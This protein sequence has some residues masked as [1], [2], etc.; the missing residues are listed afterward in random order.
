MAAL[1]EQ[2]LTHE[3]QGKYVEAET[4]RIKV[5]DSRRELDRRR[6]NEM[7]SRHRSERMEFEKGH[8]DEMTQFNNFWD[9]KA[10]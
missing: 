5:N 1:T 7:N 3:R 4:L 2:Q 6:E 10:Q 8:S 9:K